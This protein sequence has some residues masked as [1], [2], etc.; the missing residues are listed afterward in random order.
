M[1]YPSL[2]GKEDAEL[3]LIQV[4]AEGTQPS[5]AE[6]NCEKCSQITMLLDVWNTILLC[7]NINPYI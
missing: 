7:F 1:F 6:N 2:S 5:V 4:C 3:S